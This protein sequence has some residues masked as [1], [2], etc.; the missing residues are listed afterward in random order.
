V[1]YPRVFSEF[2]KAKSIKDQGQCPCQASASGVSQITAVVRNASQ[3]DIVTQALFEKNLVIDTKLVMFNK[4]MKLSNSGKYQF[5]K[6]KD[7]ILEF[8]TS[9]DRVPLVIKEIS[10]VVRSSETVISPLTTGKSSYMKWVQLTLNKL[11]PME[12]LD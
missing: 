2:N 10:G 3:V 9:S 8:V 11:Q 7:N 1:L 6:Q 4:G 12:Q 5:Y